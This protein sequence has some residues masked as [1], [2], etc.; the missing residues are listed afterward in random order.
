[1][2]TFTC[3]SCNGTL[4][5]KSDTCLACGQKIGFRSDAMTMCTAAAATAIGLR[6]CRYRVEFG[7]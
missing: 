5:F 4:S 7:V 2:R 6:P 1:M 3:D